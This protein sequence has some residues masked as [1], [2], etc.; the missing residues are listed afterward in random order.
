[1][2]QFDVYINTNRPTAKLYPY[3]LDIQNDAIDSLA[4]RIVLPLGR[5]EI[6]ANNSLTVLTPKVD[7]EGEAL[8]IMTP[9]IASVP[10]KIL[11]EPIGTLVHLREAII[12]ALDFAVTGV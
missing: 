3:L 10:V 6:L 4:T 1:M 2:A 5:A 11:K 9:Q 7:Y 8:L 12:A